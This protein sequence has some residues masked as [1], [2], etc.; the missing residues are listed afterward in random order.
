[1][2][3]SKTLMNAEIYIGGRK[4]KNSAGCKSGYCLVMVSEF[5]K[6][7]LRRIIKS[8]EYADMCIGHVQTALLLST[9]LVR[10]RSVA[11]AAGFCAFYGR[12]A[13]KMGVYEVIE[14]NSIVRGRDVHRL[15]SLAS[16]DLFMNDPSIGVNPYEKRVEER[17]KESITTA[18]N[19]LKELQGVDIS[20]ESVSV[21]ETLLKRLIMALNRA[22]DLTWLRPEEPLFPVVEQQFADYE[23]K[24]FGAPDLILETKRRDKAIVVEWKTY[25]PDVEHTKRPSEF[26]KAQVVAYSILEARRLGKTRFE[27]IFESISGINSEIVS[28]VISEIVKKL[29]HT[30]EKTIEPHELLKRRLIAERFSFDAVKS[31][32]LLKVLPLIVTPSGGYPPHPLMYKNDVYEKLAERFGKLFDIFVRVVVAAEHLALQIINV[33]D[34]LEKSM[35]YRRTSARETCLTEEGYQAY[36]YTPLSS[37]GGYLETGDPGS[38]NRY[39]CRACGFKGDGGPCEFYFGRKE[40]KDYFDKLMWWARFRVYSLRERDL[41]SHRAM[42]EL[43]QSPSILNKLIFS[44]EPLE[45]EVDF[46]RRGPQRVRLLD[47]KKCIVNTVR[48][49]RGNEDVGKFRY[50][51]FRISDVE[52]KINNNVLILRRKLRSIEKEKGV[53]GF[54]KRS[55]NLS[56]IEVNRWTNPLLSINTFVMIDDASVSE[57]DNYV[58]YECYSPSPVLMLNFVL[59]GKYVEFYKKHIPDAIVFAYEAPVDLTIME[60]RTIDALHRY[61]KKLSNNADKIVEKLKKFGIDGIEKR[62]ILYELDVIKQFIPKPKEVHGIAVLQLYRILRERIVRT[63][64]DSD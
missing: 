27:E 41:V 23:T 59:F 39:P 20:E 1:M 13:E 35:N 29:S 46:S 64:G 30:S 9:H 50:D 54:L 37:L 16:F 26:E 21:A 42:Y 49:K 6:S 56:I 48:V 8:D 36:S 3:Y 44:N 5:Y 45:L 63:G 11:R 57:D 18:C 51:Y 43:F 34:L 25:T 2:M 62:D 4:I 28:D 60:L 17:I 31:K 22:K 38:W 58:V 24:M 53:I 10:V 32:G 33:P 40:P 47:N 52:F 19:E 7:F 14:S 15:L 12:M 61:L 55:I